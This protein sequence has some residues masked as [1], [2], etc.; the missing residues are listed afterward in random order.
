MT[1]T[2]APGLLEPGHQ[3]PI[4]DP[5]PGKTPVY[6]LECSVAQPPAQPP[7]WPPCLVNLLLDPGHPHH[8]ALTPQRLETIS[9]APG[10]CLDAFIA[11][12]A[13]TVGTDPYLRAVGSVTPESLSGLFEKA[14]ASQCMPTS[15][16]ASLAAMAGRAGLV[17]LTDRVCDSVLARLET[18]DLVSTMLLDDPDLRALLL[19]RVSEIE[20]KP[21]RANILKGFGLGSTAAARVVKLLGP[22]IPQEIRHPTS[23]SA[24]DVAKADGILVKGLEGVHET[25]SGIEPEIRHWQVSRQIDP[26]ADFE[27]EVL[28]AY[29]ELGLGASSKGSALV[30]A[31]E[32]HLSTVG[33][34]RCVELGVS[35][36]IDV[37]TSFAPSKAAGVLTALPGILAEKKNL[38][39][40]TLLQG[41]GAASPEA[42]E[43]ARARLLSSIVSVAVDVIL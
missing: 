35:L 33:K 4:P 13:A 9:G 26:I 27:P 31:V 41:I 42:V 3:P 5:E 10:S 8:F 36:A 25:I 39:D 11:H 21:A 24:G 29:A 1:I 22:W 37:V 2:P 18:H 38:D 32:A 16:A 40:L 28:A 15:K 6:T 12:V 14:L 43:T 17:L 20:D 34:E 23:Q 19:A 30:R 7:A